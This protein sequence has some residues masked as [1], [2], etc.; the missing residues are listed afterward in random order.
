MCVI[1]LCQ[2]QKFVRMLFRVYHCMFIIV[3]YFT[4]ISK[5]MLLLL[6]QTI[7]S[8]II[9]IDKNYL[10]ES[11]LNESEE[12]Y[13]EQLCRFINKVFLVKISIFWIFLSWCK[14]LKANVKFQF[15]S[16]KKKRK[17]RYQN[18]GRKVCR[19]GW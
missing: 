16:G 13:C 11:Q 17:L 4:L 12:T 2:W 19:R 3:M 7:F 15:I 8:W 1:V 5:N 14:N 6:F 9:L 18:E 10:T